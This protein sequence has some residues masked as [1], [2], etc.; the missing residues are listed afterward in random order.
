MMRRISR[1][2]SDVPLRFGGAIVLLLALWALP[3]RAQSDQ[4]DALVAEG[5]ELRLQD[6]NTEALQR[7]RRAAE[8]APD[9]PRAQ[10]HLA[11]AL[12]ATG[13]WL[14]SERIMQAVVVA[15]SDD[16]VDRHKEELAR[17]LEAVRSHL[18]WLE[19]EAPGSSELWIDGHLVSALPMRAPL[20]VVAGQCTLTLRTSGRSPIDKQ[21]NIPEGRQLYL[22]LAEGPRPAR[23]EAAPTAA[24]RAP[25]AI[26]SAGGGTMRTLGVA[27]L[28]AGVA[29]VI[30]GISLGVHALVQRSERD[31]ECD[32]TGCTSRGLELD[33]RG[34][35][36]ATYADIFVVTGLA[37]L[38]AGG[39]LLWIHPGGS[40]QVRGQ[41]SAGISAVGSSLRLRW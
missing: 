1:G 7:F 36:A 3:V 21:V 19:V 35:Q 39:V 38:G 33:A 41:T 12:H 16:W 37:S 5:I 23:A 22:S 40:S 9:S 15:T 20:R 26:K 32:Q 6:H 13:D 11:L 2:R 25:V 31:R 28:G 27:L 4:V 34:R 30:A 18:A 24:Q 8:L 10:G 17:S 29:G 14:E